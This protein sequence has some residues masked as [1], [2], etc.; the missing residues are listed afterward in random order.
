MKIRPI[1]GI[2]R[3]WLWC[4]PCTLGLETI[5]DNKTFQINLGLYFVYFGI[6]LCWLKHSTENTG[7]L[8]NG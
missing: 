5:T 8:N 1:W 2:S 7:G 6:E 3:P 4:N